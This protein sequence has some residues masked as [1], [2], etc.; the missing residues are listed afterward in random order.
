VLEIGIAVPERPSNDPAT[1]KIYIAAHVAQNIGMGADGEWMILIS[2]PMDTPWGFP[3]ASGWPK[4]GGP[5]KMVVVAD[6]PQQPV[7]SWRRMHPNVACV[8]IVPYDFTDYTVE[9]VFAFSEQA[10]QEESILWSRSTNYGKSLQPT[11]RITGPQQAVTVYN[12]WDLKTG[13]YRHPSAVSDSRN[14][15]LVIGFQDDVRKNV[16]IIGGEP[17]VGLSY[18]FGTPEN[19]GRDEFAPQ[20]AAYDRDTF[21]TCLEGPA[22]STGSRNMGA[23]T[24][25]YYDAT[26]LKRLGLVHSRAL[27]PGDIAVREGEI[28]IAARL[29]TDNVPGSGGPVHALRGFPHPGTVFSVERVSDYFSACEQPRVAITQNNVVPGLASFGYTTR[30]WSKTG[31]IEAGYVYVD[32]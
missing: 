23:Y 2:G 11:K 14:G 30:D 32:L 10:S 29:Q 24:G 12:S 26:S 18:A 21:F 31:G 28:F 13:S 3:N 4:N 5:G 8:P 17:Q 19:D 16:H 22:N 20:L 1:R 7:R 27:T 9:L 6:L 25:R 15:A